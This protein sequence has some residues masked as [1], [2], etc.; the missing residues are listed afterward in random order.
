MQFSVSLNLV[1]SWLLAAAKCSKKRNLHLFPSKIRM[2]LSMERT[3]AVKGAESFTVYIPAL[4]LIPTTRP[5]CAYRR[6]AS[7]MGRH[8]TRQAP[9]LSPGVDMRLTSTRGKPLPFVVVMCLEKD[10]VLVRCRRDIWLA[11]PRRIHM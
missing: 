3:V 2:A 4:T 5:Q 11:V 9:V 10:N 7:Y 6:H 1:S 8:P